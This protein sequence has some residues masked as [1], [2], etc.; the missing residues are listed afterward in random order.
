MNFG[1]LEQIKWDSFSPTWN[2]PTPEQQVRE[3]P[4]TVVLDILRETGGA[5]F[6]KLLD[7]FR[8]QLPAYRIGYNP[9]DPKGQAAME[10]RLLD[11]WLQRLMRA[12]TIRRKPWR[13]APHYYIPPGTKEATP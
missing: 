1:K 12:G 6:G 9:R 4:R 8:D 3:H 11:R 2:N 13:G 10:T 5:T 7:S